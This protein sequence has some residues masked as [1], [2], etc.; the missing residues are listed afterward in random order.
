MARAPQELTMSTSHTGSSHLVE[1]G[2]A[3][4]S[5]VLTDRRL[6]AD[7]HVQ[8]TVSETLSLAGTASVS[9]IAIEDEKGA[10][11]EVT[12]RKTYS[13]HCDWPCRCLSHGQFERRTRHALNVERR[14]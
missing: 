3:A 1:R 10:K 2:L 8:P 11:T 13:F 7:G 5:L 12:T 9:G 14:G 6:L 4:A